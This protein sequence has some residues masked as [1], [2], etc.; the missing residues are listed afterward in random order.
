MTYPLQIKKV[1]KG[2]TTEKVLPG[3]EFEVY[4]AFDKSQIKFTKIS[5]TEYKVDPDGGVE[6]IVT[7][8]ETPVTV[9]GLNAENYI[10]VETKAPQGYNLLESSVKLADG[11][12]Y[13]HAQQVTVSTTSTTNAIQVEKVEDGTGLTL[14]STGGIGTTIF[15]IVG[16]ILIVAGAAY[17]IVRRKAAA[18]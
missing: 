2:D 5:D 3:A 1:A 11:T 18:K 12:E 14:P 9:K 17:F 4:R 13:K 7:V 15:Y 6:T 10:L 16:G 8:A